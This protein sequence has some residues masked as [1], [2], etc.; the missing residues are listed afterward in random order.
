MHTP[1]VL[2]D[3]IHSTHKH[4]VKVGGLMESLIKLNSNQLNPSALFKCKIG[5]ISFRVGLDVNSLTVYEK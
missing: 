3:V 2:H 5:D 1:L 4:H